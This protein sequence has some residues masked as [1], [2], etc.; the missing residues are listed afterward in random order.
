L[1]VG[2]AALI[3]SVPPSSMQTGSEGVIIGTVEVTGLLCPDATPLEH[4]INVINPVCVA[5]IFDSTRGL[6]SF[7]C[8][9]WIVFGRVLISSEHS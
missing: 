2:V 5:T 1:E 9:H 7:F 8:T 4:L 3:P 6:I